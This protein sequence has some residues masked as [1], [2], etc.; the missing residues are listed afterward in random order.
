MTKFVTEKPDDDV[1]VFSLVATNNGGITLMGNGKPIL[2][3][4]AEG[5]LERYHHV[6]TD[7]GLSL[8]NLGRIMDT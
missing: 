2:D 7:L 1:V 5:S 3:I 8:D 6:P 4:S